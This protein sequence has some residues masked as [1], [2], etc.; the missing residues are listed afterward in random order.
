MIQ[1]VSFRARIDKFAP[2]SDGIDT[3]EIG[4][5]VKRG[6]RRCGEGDVKGGSRDDWVILIWFRCVGRLQTSG[7]NAAVMAAWIGTAGV[8]AAAGFVGSH[9]VA[10]AADLPLLFPMKKPH[11]L[12]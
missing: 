4:S 10:I 7:L 3:A 12:R 8:T 9:D 11:G 6:I 1:L 5:W 2:C